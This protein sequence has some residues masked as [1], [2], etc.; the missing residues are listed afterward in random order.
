MPMPI[1]FKTVFY[2]EFAGY[3]R[4]GNAYIILGVYALLSFAATFYVSGYFTLDNTSLAS[5]SLSAGN[6]DG[7]DTGR[8]HALLDGRAPAGNR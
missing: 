3:F 5:F 8:Y 7:A 4:S 6:P 1:G 2:K